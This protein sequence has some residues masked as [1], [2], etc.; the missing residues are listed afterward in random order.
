ML[1][2]QELRNS[3][4]SQR[5]ELSP[6]QHAS[7][8]I[9]LAEHI[10]SSR[11]FLNSQHIAFYLPN[12]GETDLQP[13]IEYAWQM[14]K[15]CYLPVLGL[16]N[17]RRLWFLPYQAETNLI[18]NRFGIPEPQHANRDRL[19]KPFTLDLILMPLVAFDSQGNRLGMG[20]GFYDRTLGFLI[21]RQHWHKPR[22]FGTAFS[23]QHVT[24]LDRQP[25]DVPL[26]GIATEQDIT[27]FRR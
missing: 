10:A 24:R 26:D 20:G 13:L 1:N 16:R 11:Y 2:R 17:S 3:L 5:R 8:S 22:L 18:P 23:F 27:L 9:Q 12:D 14:K 4:R 25:W 21:H 15:Q 7:A 6:Q 19:L